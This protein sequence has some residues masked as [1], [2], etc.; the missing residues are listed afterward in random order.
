MSSMAEYIRFL[1]ENIPHSFDILSGWDLD[2]QVHMRILNRTREQTSSVLIL[3]IQKNVLI[4]FTQELILQAR[5]SGFY[6]AALFLR[7][8]STS[9]PLHMELSSS[10][11]VLL[12]F[13]KPSQSR[14]RSRSPASFIGMRSECN[15]YS[16]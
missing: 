9:L 16:F 12:L 13:S 2:P 10:P 6:F 7:S 8:F 1:V 3:K 5:A 11:V 4:N 14:S 15:Y